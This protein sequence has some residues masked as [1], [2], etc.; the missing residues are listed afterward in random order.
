MSTVR[1]AA[2]PAAAGAQQATTRRPSWRN[3]L[4]ADYEIMMARLEV[5]LDFE[6]DVEEFL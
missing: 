1:G 2:S 6:D 5:K 3:E 4:A